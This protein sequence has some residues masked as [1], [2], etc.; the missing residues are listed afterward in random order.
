MNVLAGGE[1]RTERSRREKKRWYDIR[2]RSLDGGMGRAVVKD[3]SP[4][5]HVL[6]LHA[7]PHSLGIRDGWVVFGP[8]CP[9]LPD[10]YPGTHPIQISAPMML[11]LC[12]SPSRVL[13]YTRD[14]F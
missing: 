10:S 6:D 7:L 11:P 14:R 12:V 9:W 13:T 8:R 3:P 2:S 5:A 4:L 1:G